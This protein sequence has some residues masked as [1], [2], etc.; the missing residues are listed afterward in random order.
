MKEAFITVKKV[1]LKNNCP[2]CFSNDG[3]QMTFK[4]KYFE[5]AFQRSITNTV[6]TEIYCNVCNTTIY[7]E[8]WTED[9]ERV[10][11]YQ[12]KAFTPKPT[13]RQF[14]KLFWG[15]IITGAVLIIAVTVLTLVNLQ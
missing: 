12:Q 14:K 3:L 10:R 15:F 9:I 4:Q 1:A 6:V 11:D 13:S 8:R 7:P 5:N 2:E